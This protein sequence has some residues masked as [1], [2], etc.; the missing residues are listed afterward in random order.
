MTI[1]DETKAKLQQVL[2]D[3]VSRAVAAFFAVVVGGLVMWAIVEIRF[4]K[5]QQSRHEAVSNAMKG[6]GQGK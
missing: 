4:H 6:T 1:T 2:I 5:Y 3:T